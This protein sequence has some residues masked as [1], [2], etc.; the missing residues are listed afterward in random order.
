[1]VRLIMEREPD[2]AGMFETR[3][4]RADKDG[5]MST[6]PLVLSFGGG[7][8]SA[9][10]IVGL[11]ERGI[12]PDLILFADTGGEKPETYEFVEIV[13]VWCESHGFPSIITVKNDGKYESLEAECFER[14]T[15][16]PIVMGWRTCSDKYKRRP[17]EKY[18]KQNGLLPCVMAVGIDAG[19][20]QRLG[21]FDTKT[22]THRYFLVEWGWAR[23]GCI[24]ALRR[25]GLPVPIK[26]ACWFCPSS[27]SSEVVWLKKVHPLLFQRSVEMERNA[28]GLMVKGLGRHWSWEQVGK[29]DEQQL[30]LFPETVP[31]VCMCFDGDDEEAA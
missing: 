28:E 20:P 26:S 7:V 12:R 18:L 23:V 22:I 19:E 15:L 10:M 14:K 1:M 11:H 16:P 31:I 4:L 9:A 24:D 25:N 8:N 3:E 6:K 30:G 5:G 21:D 17:I 13:N 27:K 2:L 29:T